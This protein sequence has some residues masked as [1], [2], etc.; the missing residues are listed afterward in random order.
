M[1]RATYYVKSRASRE[2]LAQLAKTAEDL[3]P[4]RQS[5]R[6][7]KFSSELIIEN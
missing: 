4:T 7:G 6:A 1:I 5:L 2:R 3:S